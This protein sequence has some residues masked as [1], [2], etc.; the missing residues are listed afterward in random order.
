MSLYLNKIKAIEQISQLID[1]SKRQNQI[2]VMTNGCFD[3]LHPGHISYLEKAKK[4]GHILIVAVNSDASIKRLKGTNRPINILNDRLHMLAGL[5]SI[6]WL[7]SFEEDTPESIIKLIKPDILVKGADYKIEDIAGSE[8][9]MSYGGQVKLIELE[10]GYSSSKII[11]RI[12]SI[13]L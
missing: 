13:D 7:I 11:D 8:Y 5:A 6:D 10:K 9:V 12:K 1:N 3:I 4:L 2:V